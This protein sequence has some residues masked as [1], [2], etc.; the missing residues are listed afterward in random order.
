M[1]AQQE[2]AEEA[3]NR[4]MVPTL[5]Q[6]GLTIEETQIE[7][8]EIV[9]NDRDRDIEHEEHANVPPP[10]PEM[11]EL[12]EPEADDNVSHLSSNLSEPGLCTPE[13]PCSGDGPCR[14]MTE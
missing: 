8:N 12:Q 1:I 2:E 7:F 6:L 14:H 13:N 3:I 11:P 9:A 4:G 10:D 5:E